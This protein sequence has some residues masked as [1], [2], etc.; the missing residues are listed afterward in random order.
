MRQMYEG[1]IDKAEVQQLQVRFF[2]TQMGMP[3]PTI[4]VVNGPAVGQG[5]T[6][7]LSCDVVY[8]SSRASFADPHV[9]MG[10]VS[11]TSAPSP[12]LSRV[13]R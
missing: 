11:R 1:E 7:A 8:A 4:A 10:L 2:R 9:Q 6:F 3:A 13:L 5:C 12:K